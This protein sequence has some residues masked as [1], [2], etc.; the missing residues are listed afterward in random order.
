MCHVHDMQSRRAYIMSEKWVHNRKVTSINLLASVTPK[1]RKELR[2]NL[3]WKIHIRNAYK[4]LI[5]KHDRK[6][7]WET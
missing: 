6:T 3:G 7:D 1:P 2:V 5:G 4:I